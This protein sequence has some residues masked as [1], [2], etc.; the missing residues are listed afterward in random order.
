MPRARLKLWQG[1]ALPPQTLLFLALCA[2]TQTTERS[3]EIFL[4][5]QPIGMEETGRVARAISF[6]EVLDLA[7]EENLD[8]KL[9][10]AEEEIG[11]S[12]SR[13]A[14]SKLVPELRL[15]AGTA[16][17]D[18]RV[19]GSFGELRDTKYDTKEAHIALSYHVN[20][21]ARIE[22]SLAA[23]RE[24]DAA[25]YGVLN[26]RQRLLLRVAELYS[27]VALTQ[28]G[29]QIARQRAQDSEEFLRIASARQRGGIGLGSDVA[30]ARAEL[31]RE[32]Q[33]LIQSREIWQ[34][35]SVRLA[36]VLR[37]DPGLPLIAAEERL[38]PLDFTP[39]VAG[40]EAER[41][42]RRRP[43]VEASRKRMEAAAKR[44][45][46][47]WWELAGPELTAE[48]RETY[49]GESVSDTGDRRNAGV[50]VGWTLSLGKLET[51]LERR[52][53]RTTAELRAL[54]TEERAAGEA[55]GAL[56]EL[57]GARE[58]LPLALTGLEAAQQNHRIS[59]AQ[60]K[61][62]TAIGL[63]VIDAANRLAGARLDLARAIVDYNLA[64]VKLLA[65]TGALQVEL[66][67]VAGPIAP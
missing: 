7:L 35:A 51:I 50:F 37:L 67:R 12:R 49:I 48:L 56:H 47:A 52:A 26:T 43:D 66:L 62:G 9:A 15:G 54:R 58:R 61:S 2:A 8:L 33:E 27:N 29:F 22:D 3:S 1:F 10:L 60:F 13:G 19:Q 59:L 65:A 30:R 14:L 16:Q 64:Q 25:V 18:G 34:T 63:E 36:V 44:F 21:G 23:R 4:E 41:R 11:R 39:E 46:S 38:A 57:D 24:L 31:A 45:S 28:V 53:E 17:T 32:Q 42:A 5:I 55:R 20:P 40:S 6:D